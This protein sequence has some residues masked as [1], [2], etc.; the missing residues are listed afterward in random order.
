M[1]VTNH[2]LQRKYS[3]HQTVRSLIARMMTEG[4]LT[5]Q[6]KYEDVTVSPSK[7]QDAKIQNKKLRVFSVSDALDAVILR[8]S[9]ANIATSYKQRKSIPL[10]D[11]AFKELSKVIKEIE[12]EQNEKNI[13]N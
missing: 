11:L 7:F 1:K 9:K 2:I 10:L 5:Y 12:G 4:E 8:Q 13:Y 3:V 6:L